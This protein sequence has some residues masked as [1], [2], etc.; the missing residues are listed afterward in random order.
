VIAHSVRDD[1][2]RFELVG[3]QHRLDLDGPFLDTARAP[4][5]PQR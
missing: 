2:R 5:S 1:R 3:P 4:A